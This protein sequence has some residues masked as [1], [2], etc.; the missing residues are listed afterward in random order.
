MIWYAVIII[1]RGGEIP[2]SL[3][4]LAAGNEGFVV[5]RVRVEGIGEV[6]YGSLLFPLLGK[7]ST[8]LEFPGPC[9]AAG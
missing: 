7:Y 1:E 8:L 4:C 6:I 3:P 2:R 9:K 5:C